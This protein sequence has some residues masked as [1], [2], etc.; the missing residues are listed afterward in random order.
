MQL[1]HYFDRES[2]PKNMDGGS[3][4]RL[5]D[6]DKDINNNN[7]LLILHS[8]EKSWSFYVSVWATFIWTRFSTGNR[9]RDK[10]F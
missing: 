8:S 2:P 3:K 5:Q 9:I 7:V 1:I 6:N 10:P 4:D